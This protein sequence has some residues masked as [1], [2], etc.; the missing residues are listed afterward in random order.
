MKKL[1]FI[2]PV[3]AAL[4]LLFAPVS[5]GATELD[6]DAQL[7]LL[8]AM[9][10]AQAN[11]QL[12]GTA[13]PATPVE[14]PVVQ[15]VVAP[16]VE[17]PVVQPTPA[18]EPTPIGDLST[19]VDVC[20]ATQTCVYYENGNA[21]LASPCVTGSPGRSTPTGIFMI[22]MCTPGKYLTGPTWHVWV[23]RWMRFSGNC[24]LHDASW[25][26]AFGGDIYLH[27]G[28]H[29]CVNLPH[30]MAVALYDRVG[31]GTVVVVH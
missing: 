15:P 8:A 17:Q 1:I 25:R 28:S 7:Q 14:Q 24:G 31:I 21:V 26:K 6:A 3:F 20:I 11:A 9:L 19:Y 12:Y 16:V 13:V 29:G 5:A 30:D 18:P 10:Q 2:L 27:N 4:F 23:D 22:N